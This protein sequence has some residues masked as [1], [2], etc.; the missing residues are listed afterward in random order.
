MITLEALLLEITLKAEWQPRGESGEWSRSV[1]GVNGKVKGPSE[2][3]S[4][5]HL[6]HA[7]ESAESLLQLRTHLPADVTG[8]GSRKQDCMFGKAKSRC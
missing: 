3:R 5:C 6:A 4:V 1:F 8:E 7:E 2:D